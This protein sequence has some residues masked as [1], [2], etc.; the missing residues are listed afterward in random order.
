MFKVPEIY[1][2]KKQ[3]TQEY[4]NN[5]VFVVPHFKIL[6][7]SFYIIA[8]EGCSWEHLSISLRR[9]ELKKEFGV[10]RCATW[11]EM[12]WIKELFWGEEDCVVQ[13]HPPK[14]QYVSQHEYCL[15][16][17]RPIGKNIQAPDPVLVGILKTLI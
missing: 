13:F 6:N 8:S 10:E 3:S 4:G 14:S 17:W 9:K 7:Y 11:G 15:H 2:D 1:R 16:L 5:G 12:C